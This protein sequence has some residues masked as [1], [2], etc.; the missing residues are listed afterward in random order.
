[1]SARHAC[2]NLSILLQT[3]LA[4]IGGTKGDTFI[5]LP[6]LLTRDSHDYA[7]HTHAHPSTP[8]EVSLIFIHNHIHGKI[9]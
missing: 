7:I 1:M 4:D 9:A 6:A 5:K 3:R 2:N 8:I